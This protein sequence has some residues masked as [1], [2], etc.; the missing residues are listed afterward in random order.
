MTPGDSV[1]IAL[2]ASACLVASAFCLLTL[3][4]WFRRRNPHDLAWSVAMALFVVGAGALW[5][6]ESRGWSPV[7][8]RLFFL[9][10]AVLNVAWLALGTVY[11]LFGRRIGDTTRTV[12]LL[13][14]GYATG[15]VTMAPM[16]AP[17]D[18][19]GFPTAKELFGTTPRIL[20]A[21]GSGVPALVIIVGA[22]WSAVR[23]ARGRV[24]AATASARRVASSPRM[25]AL[26]NVLIALGAVVLSASGTIAGRLGK[27][28]AF[29]VTLAV[30]IVVLFA[31]FMVASNA[32]G[33]RPRVSAVLA[34]A[35]SPSH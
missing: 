25:L 16:K 24:P 19:D 33:T 35:L 12:L 20:A 34:A 22:L 32:V 4:R 18:P 2:A 15:V 5:W 10:G 30:G 8:F 9:T 11:L 26:G 17:I 3:D 14:S 1:A 7:T 27:D 28:K 21:V 6:A 23:V 31:G 29:A 13:L